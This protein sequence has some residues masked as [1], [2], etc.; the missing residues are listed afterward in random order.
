MRRIT[1]IS[2]PAIRV[3]PDPTGSTAALISRCRALYHEEARQRAI[4]GRRHPPLK[5]A[6]E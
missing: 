6:G 2:R 5:L 3:V 4:E 1:A